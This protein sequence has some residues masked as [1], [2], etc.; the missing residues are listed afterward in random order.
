FH[1]L[2][3]VMQSVALHDEL[4]FQRGGSGIQLSCSN[5]ALPV[6]SANLVHRAATAFLES[7]RIADGIS[8]HLTKN[9]PMAAGLGGGSGN[10][11]I[12]LL[13]LNEIFGKPLSS[14][15]L[16]PIAARLGSDVPFFLQ[17]QPAIAI[18][19]GEQVESLE[20]FAALR[21]A[22]ML[23]IH[24]GFGISTPWAYQSLAKFPEALRGRP[25]R[26]REL[27]ALLAGDL[28][29]AGAAFYN[30]LEAPALHKHPILALYQEFLRAHGA[31][32]T[33]MSGSGSATFALVRGQSAAEVLREKFI[34]KFGS[35]NWTAIAP[36]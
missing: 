33:L 31:T 8:I 24:P 29:S 10:A 7:A 5:P 15:Q 2:E 1:E 28:T 13:G 27:V 20:P 25:G 23:L 4:T 36:L 14:E 21:G 35:A 6:D 30:S 17:H 3:T 26:A 19:R 22:W 12:T 9:I 32:A 34:A 16:F 18:G 11:A